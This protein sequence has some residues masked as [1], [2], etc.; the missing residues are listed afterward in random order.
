MKT[1]KVPT[2]IKEINKIR[3]KKGLELMVTEDGELYKIPTKKTVKAKEKALHEAISDLKWQEWADME[4][5][6]R[7]EL[8]VEYG[9]FS[10][11][12]TTP[13]SKWDKIT[14][15]LTLTNIAIVVAIVMTNW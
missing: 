15:V 7:K 8:G 3:A 14:L 4:V 11:D 10:W 2:V 1:T 13:M 6:T 12:L 5:P 9:T